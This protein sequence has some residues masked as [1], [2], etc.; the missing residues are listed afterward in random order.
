MFHGA[1]VVVKLGLV[2]FPFIW[3]A[4]SSSCSGVPG[5]VVDVPAP[6]VGV[7]DVP[8]V[9]VGVVEVPAVVVGVVT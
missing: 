6:V 3:V 1:A 7:V 5:A 9:V 8:A 2:Q 4:G